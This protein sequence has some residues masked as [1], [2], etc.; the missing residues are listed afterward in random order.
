MPRTAK[1]KKTKPKAD[2]DSLKVVDLKVTRGKNL[3]LAQEQ[4]MRYAMEFSDLYRKSKKKTLELEEKLK[5][6]PLSQQQSLMYAKELRDI[7][8]KEKKEA[9]H[10]RHALKGIE[11][12]Y[13][14]TLIALVNA[15]DVREHETHNHSRRVMEYTLELARKAGLRKKEII[16]I[17]RGCLLHDIGKIGVSDNIL[18]KKGR[19]TP[20]EW[21]DMRKHPYIGYKMLEGIKFLEGASLMVLTHQERFDG[22]GYPQRLKGKAIPVG[23]RL[24]APMD[25]LDALTSDRPYR[26]ARSFDEALEEILRCT[27]TQFD[28]WAIDIF[29][30]FPIDTWQKI[31]LESE[32]NNTNFYPSF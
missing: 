10:L 1:K 4:A 16:D 6:L 13:Q 11:D 8:L 26:K 3:V 14:S 32:K 25:T 22:T 28:P 23:S 9:K 24:F 2:K 18:L 20:D 31:K 7:Y 30:S 27:G 12:A 19:L 15:L 5:A 17:N 21:A 29:L